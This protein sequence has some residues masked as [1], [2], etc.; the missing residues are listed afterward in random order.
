MQTELH[1]KQQ[2]AHKLS[3]ANRTAIE[4][5]S[6]V[7][8]TAFGD[9]FSGGAVDAI[10]GLVSTEIPVSGESISIPIV[11]AGHGLREWLGDKVYKDFRAYAQTI[12]VRSWESSTELSRKKLVTDTSGATDIALRGWLGSQKRMYE[13][14]VIDQ[15]LT[16]PTGYDGVALI[17]DTHPNTNSTGDNKTTDA[18][19]H[20]SFRAM[21]EQMRG[22]TDE[23]GNDLAIT[24]N[25]LVV[26]YQLYDTALEVTNAERPLFFDANAAEATASVVGAVKIDNIYTGQVN[27][28][29]SNRIRG[30]QWF[31]MDLTKG[32]KPIIVTRL[33]AFESHSQTDMTDEQRFARDKYRFSIEGDYGIGA[34]PW[35][36]I[37]GKIAA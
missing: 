21:L 32:L 15:M 2:E 23:W 4:N 6:I 35:P 29:V 10:A 18:L 31:L 7:W 36:L 12:T 3:V 28:V 30:T 37:A 22:F 19:S 9:F 26:G 1:L 16:N 34:G 14:L 13:Y 33:R 5:A 11:T 27:V 20:A 17:H 25:T 24:P 8:Q